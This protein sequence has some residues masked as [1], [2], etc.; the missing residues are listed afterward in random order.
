[1]TQTIEIK[2]HIG[3]FSKVEI[4][5]I[6]IEIKEQLRLLEIDPQIIR[7]IYTAAVELLDNIMKHSIVNDVEEDTDLI[8]EFPAKFYLKKVDNLFVMYSGNIILNKCIESLKTKIEV[9]QSLKAVNLNHLY[10]KKLLTAEISDK[11][12]A[13]LGL[14]IIARLSGKKIKFDFEKINDKFSYFAL[15]IE[16]QNI[17]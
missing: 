4:D 2:H 11:G 16:F 17:L 12:G 13:G 7:R 15:Q 10:K 1:M 6:L 5:E 8:I 3:D 9:L 14:I